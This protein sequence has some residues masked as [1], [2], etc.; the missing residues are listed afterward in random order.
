M[1]LTATPNHNTIDVKTTVD[2]VQVFETLQAWRF[3]PLRLV[4]NLVRPDDGA[5]G[6]SGDQ[7]GDSAPAG[8]RLV[9]ALRKQMG[10]A[11]PVAFYCTSPAIT[12]A[13]L[14]ECVPFV[15]TTR[16]EDVL[17]FLKTGEAIVT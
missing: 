6:S 3:Q 15:L 16:Q 1:L 2:A 4:T 8:I 17:H 9:R 14:A 7:K 5:A 10:I 11:D 12:S 13:L